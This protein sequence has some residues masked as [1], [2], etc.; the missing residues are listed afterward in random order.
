MASVTSA[1]GPMHLGM[2]T[3]KNMI[4]VAVLMAGEEIPVLDRVW[5]EEGR[6]GM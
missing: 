4:V 6:C 5:N 2:D 1:A 3:S